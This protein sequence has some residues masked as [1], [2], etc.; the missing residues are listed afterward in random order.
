MILQLVQVEEH[1][2]KQDNK[3]L[4]NA[5]TN[6]HND[7]AANRFSPSA[8]KTGTIDR[9]AGRRNDLGF[10]NQAALNAAL[11]GNSNRC[12]S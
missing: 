6:P 9:S 3:R 12:F 7:T 1:K 11:Y 2:H 10:S 4:I 8:Q 5:Y